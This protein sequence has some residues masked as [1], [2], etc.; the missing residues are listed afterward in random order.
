M[1]MDLENSVEI[2]DLVTQVNNNPQ[3][4]DDLLKEA[5]KRGHKDVLKAMWEDETHSLARN[6]FFQ[7]QFRN[8]T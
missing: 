7:D 5:D 6:Q 1:V 8:S 2:S 4:L 3:H